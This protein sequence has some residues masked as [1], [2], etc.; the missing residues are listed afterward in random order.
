MGLRVCRCHSFRSLDLS[1]ARDCTSVELLPLGYKLMLTSS[2]TTA[3]PIVCVHG[4]QNEALLWAAWMTEQSKRE[5]VRSKQS[6]F[7][8][9]DRLHERESPSPGSCDIVEALLQRGADKDHQ[10]E[11]TRGE[12]SAYVCLF[13]F[14]FLF[15]YPKRKAFSQCQIHLNNY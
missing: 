5:H 2:R 1:R 8:W 6:L 9:L 4:L 7:V 10:D 14:L 15:C 12:I 11:V 13:N 3:H